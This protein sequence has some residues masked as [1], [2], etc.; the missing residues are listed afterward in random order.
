MHSQ[1]LN[2]D[3]ILKQIQ[4]EAIKSQQG[5]LK[6]YL[7]AAAGVGKTYAML[8]DA[9]AAQARGVDVLVGIVECHGRTETEQLLKKLEILPRQHILYHGKELKEFDLD[10]ALIRHPEL[11][12]VDEMAHSN[13][14]GLRHNK[15]WQDIKELLN[16]GID[17]YSTLNIQHIESLNNDVAQIV[18]TRITETVPDSMLEMADSIELIDLPPE[19]LIKRLQEGKVYV[20][21]QAKI[22]IERF[23]RKGNLTALRELA[24]RISA[25]YVGQQMLNYR[26]IQGIKHIWPTKSKILVCIGP[27]R[28]SLKLI[29][30][31]KRMAVSLKAKWIA[32]HVAT[33]SIK[34]QEQILPLA[35]Q[36]LRLAEQLGAET[37]VLAGF[38]VVQEIMTFA[39]EKNVTQIMVWKTI[40]NR[41]RDLFFRNLADEMVRE[42]GEL[43]IY[44]MTGKLGRLKLRRQV[45]TKPPFKLKNYRIPLVIIALATFINFLIFP[46]LHASNLIMIYVLGVTIIALFG[47]A[48]PALFSSILSVLAYKFFFVPPFYSFS[49]ADVQYFF[50]LLIMLLIT[51][52]I[53]QLAIRIRRQATSARTL[54]HQTSGLLALSRQMTSVHRVEEAL[55][56]GLKAMEDLFNSQILALIPQNRHF[57]CYST[58]GIETKSLDE[59]EYSIAKWVLDMGEMAGFATETLADAKALYLPLIGL[60]NPVA[61]LK[62]TPN[63]KHYFTPE[64]IQFLE[65]YAHQIA[66]TLEVIG[67]EKSG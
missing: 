21:K 17:V 26:E 11:I 56:I 67:F 9:Q 6:I 57:Q 12:L 46:Y 22:A 38:D 35:I 48:G 8:S 14:P 15:R 63:D 25:D 65:S 45:K 42:S 24:L 41:W 64:Q 5:R 19:E 29:R 4:Q 30:A 55:S 13:A 50:T 52:I 18:N 27:G 66:L 54:Q 33:P 34:A 2:P 32:V 3:K 39:R 47:Q 16:R 58:R 43:D 62:I 60:R 10:S 37:A 40:R 49:I 53:S 61:V 28:E 23:F 36:N 44:V 51:Q 1:R 7:G 31:A 20:P 59:K